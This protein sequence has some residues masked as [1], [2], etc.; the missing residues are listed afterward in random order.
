MSRYEYPKNLWLPAKDL[1]IGDV[2]QQLEG[3]FGTAIVQ[4]ADEDEV[5]LFRP[6]AAHTN[7]VYSSGLICLTGTEETI[8]ERHRSTLY[9]V[10]QREKFE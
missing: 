1:R 8:L 4:S 5:I 6:Y 3:P 7:Y 2:I 9:L 10:Y